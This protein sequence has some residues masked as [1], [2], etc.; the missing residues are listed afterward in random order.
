MKQQLNTRNHDRDAAGMLYIYPVISRRA[1][2]ISIGINLN[3]N[4]ACNWHCAYCQVPNLVRG[5]APP[6]DLVRLRQE[7]EQMLTEM[8]EGDFLRQRVPEQCR[9]ICDIAISG[10]GEPTSCR[11]FGQVID[12][13]AEIM[14][15][16]ELQ[17]PLRLITNG[18][19]LH[20]P[21]IRAGIA[22]MA[23]EGGE[24]WVKVDSASE[25][26]IRRINGIKLDA[27]RLRRQV[28]TAAR[29]CPTW[30]QTCMLAWDGQAPSEEEIVAYLALLSRLKQEQVPLQGVLLYGLA[31]PSQQPESLHLSPLDP[32]WLEQMAERIR[33]LNITVRV[34]P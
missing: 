22:A 3:P 23:R 9:Q 11:E 12:I 2:G 24:V 32:A 27:A 21:H 8:L 29:L 25:A 18:S 16:N 33:Q 19:Y 28:E 20:K 34:S 14:R 7:L 31:R 4:N 5:S 15:S 30:I 26:G 1:G 13:V 17:V 6:I 10:N